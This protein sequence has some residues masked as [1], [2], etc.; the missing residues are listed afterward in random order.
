V[1]SGPSASPPPVSRRSLELPTLWGRLSDAGLTTTVLS[2]PLTYPAE[3]VNGS[4]V[5]GMFTPQ[6]GRGATH[7]PGLAAELEAVDAMPKFALDVSVARAR[8]RAAERMARS[9]DDDAAAYFA[10]IADMTERLR[11]TALYLMERP[12]DLFAAVFV[13]TDR[14]Q[15]LFWPAIETVGEST[16]NPLSRSIR[17]SYRQV[18]SALG[19]IVRAAGD[20]VHVIL[21]SDHGFGPC[22][23]RFGV[24]RW[25]V[26]AGYA[27]PRRRRLYTAVRNALEATGLK[28][29][30]RRAAGRGPVGRAV[31]REFLPFDWER[32]RAYFVPGSYGVRINLRGRERE[33]IVEPGNEYDELRA[34]LAVRLAGIDAS[35][36]RGS[37]FSAVKR[38]EDVYE[39]PSVEWAPDLLLEPNPDIG[40]V[41]GMGNAESGP[42]VHPARKS[43]GN[44]RP[45]GILLVS[46]TGVRTSA[47]HVTPSIA[48]IAPT[49]MR[50]F[51][52]APPQEMDGRVL[53][54]LFE[55]LPHV[56]RTSSNGSGASGHECAYSEDEERKV[57]D[58]LESLGYL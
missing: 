43:V 57:R 2:V 13:A 20:D 7:P 53:E 10:D 51:G 49:V 34:E 42:L 29:L 44:H 21:M 9:L 15:H 41:P 27:R 28:G 14:I 36:G 48:D 55:R 1:G 17:A 4:L 37:V 3:S 46:G 19:D 22:P 16:D 6:G 5:T 54:G 52:F 32:T 58:E 18:D 38:R 11:R 24:G 8:G 26:E 47:S 25:L 56:T 31:R 33:G 45:E 50:L 12:W 23:G 40:Y 35:G 30:A 39:G